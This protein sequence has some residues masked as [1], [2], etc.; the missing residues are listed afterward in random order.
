MLEIPIVQLFMAGTFAIITTEFIKWMVGVT[1]SD[2]GLHSGHSGKILKARTATAIYVCLILISNIGAFYTY[3]YATDYLYQFS[4]L[5]T[6]SID[7]IL[8]LGSIIVI[9]VY[10][11]TN[12][13]NRK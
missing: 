11:K 8:I 4:V 7:S 2:V 13:Y 6:V 10:L 5:S 9:W 3:E 12:H 1:E